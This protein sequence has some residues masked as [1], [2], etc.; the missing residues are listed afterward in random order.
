MHWLKTGFLNE[1]IAL[2]FSKTDPI[3]KL[4]NLRIDSTNGVIR[5]KGHNTTCPRD[6]RLGASYVDCLTGE[7]NV[8]QSTV[9]LS[10]GWGNAVGDIVDTLCDYCEYNELDPKRIYVWICCLCNK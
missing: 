10:Y 1:V 2:G 9:M 3:Y 8:G 4:E 5:S 6:G 7:D